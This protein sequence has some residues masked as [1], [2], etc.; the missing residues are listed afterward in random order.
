MRPLR[1]SAGPWGKI[2]LGVLAGAAVILGGQ[3]WLWRSRGFQ[4]T[5]T[6]NPNL[7]SKW[8]QAATSS[9]GPTLVIVGSSRIQ[10]GFSPPVWRAVFPRQKLVQLAIDG[11]QPTA[12]LLDLARDERF[13]GTV[14]LDTTASIILWELPGQQP[15]VDNFHRGG[16]LAR[17]AEATLEAWVQ[18]RAV[19]T[20]AHLGGIQ[21]LAADLG[22]RSLRPFYVRTFPDRSRRANFSFWPGLGPQLPSPAV[23]L[24]PARLGVVGSMRAAID[25]IRRRG[26]RVILV[27]MPT[28]GQT[29]AGDSRNYPRALWWDRFTGPDGRWAINFEDVPSLRGFQCGD[30]SHLDQRDADRFTAA[31]ADECRR[32]GLND[33]S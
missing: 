9:A 26:G 2:W 5:V 3:E 17:D 33:G 23:V 7:W 30:D 6:D 25:R 18:S 21:L 1:S 11:T 27:R 22:H 13:H 24:N 32:R 20:A 31:L 19:I 4:P 12:S 14:L 10:L 8:R 28:S 15:W 29:L 16:G